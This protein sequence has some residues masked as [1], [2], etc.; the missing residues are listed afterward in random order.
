M[1]KQELSVEL[2]K[3]CDLNREFGPKMIRQFVKNSYDQELR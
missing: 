3:M 2:Q 1:T